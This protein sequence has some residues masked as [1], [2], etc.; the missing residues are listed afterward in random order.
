MILMMSFR[1]LSILGLACLSFSFGQVDE[2]TLSD[3]ASEAVSLFDGKTFEGWEGD[4]QNSF[5][6]Q[7]G[8][9]VAGS[10]DADVPRNEFLTSKGRY[11]DFI[12]RVKVKLIGEG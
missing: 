2:T 11:K 1:L 5:R 3:D 8:A 4:I 10:L 6:I 12:L 7:E 9:I